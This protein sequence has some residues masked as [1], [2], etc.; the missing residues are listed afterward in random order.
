MNVRSLSK[1]S[2]AVMTLAVLSYCGKKSH[3]A[4]SP[5]PAPEPKSEAPAGPDPTKTTPAGTVPANTAT[6]YMQPSCQT[7]DEILGLLLS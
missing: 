5:A 3:D 4:A 2:A 7:A 6:T 1:L